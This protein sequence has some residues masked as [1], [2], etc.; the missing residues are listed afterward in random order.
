MEVSVDPAEMAHEQPGKTMRIFISYN[1]QNSAFVS[2]IV[3][4]LKDGIV[5]SREIFFDQ[6]NLRGGQQWTDEIQQALLGSDACIV[7]IGEQGIGNWQG[8]E[9]LAAINQYVDTRGEFRVIPVIIPHSNREQMQK[10]FPWFLADMQW[11]EFATETDPDAFQKLVDGLLKGEASAFRPGRDTNPYKG[12]DF[13]DVQDAPLFFGRT[14]DLN[15]VFYKKLLLHT[16]TGSRFLAIVGDSGSGKSSFARAGLLAA[17]QA[18]RFSGSEHWKQVI[19]NPEDNPL[20]KLS[21]ALQAAGMIPDAKKLEDEAKADVAAL[22]RAVEIYGRKMILLVDQFEEV[23]TQCKEHAIRE[24]FLN[25]ILEALKSQHFICIITLRSDFYASFSS[26]TAFADALQANNYTITGFDYTAAGAEWER[27][28]KAIIQKPARMMGVRISPSLT[29]KIIQDCKGISGVLPV[30]QLALSRLYN[31]KREDVASI[32]SQHYDTL[33]NNKGIAGIIEA[34]ANNCWNGLTRDGSDKRMDGLIK[35]IFI[36]LVE[37]TQN[38]EDVRKTVSKAELIRNLGV[39]FSQHEVEDMLAVLSGAE[40]RLIRI[41]KDDSDSGIF[42]VDVIHEVLIRQWELFRKWINERREAIRYRDMLEEHLADIAVLTGRRLAEAEKWIDNNKDLATPEIHLLVARSRKN[43]NRI[44]Y[45]IGAVL[46]IGV[47]SALSAWLYQP[48]RQCNNCALVKTWREGNYDVDEVHTLVLSGIDNIKY[49]RCFG[50][51][52]SLTLAGSDGEYLSQ[53]SIDSLPQRLKYLS[54]E[55]FMVNDTV[56]QFATF[57]QLQTLSI[58]HLSGLRRLSITGLDSLTGLHLVG[59][60]SYKTLAGIGEL[61]NLHTLTLSNLRNVRSLAG[62]EGFANLQ[63]LTLSTLSI[64]SLD[65]IQGLK[66]LQTLA[67]Y[68]LPDVHDLL[69]IEKLKKSLQVLSIESHIDTLAGIENMTNLH[70]LGLTG[71]RIQSLAAL[72]NLR[73]LQT[74]YLSDIDKPILPSIQKLKSLHHLTLSKVHEDS[75]A[76]IQ[77]LDSLETLTLSDIQI[78]DLRALGSLNLHALYLSDLRS[79]NGLAGI[80]NLKNLQTLKI[81]FLG[82]IGPF[83]LTGLETLQHLTTFSAESFTGFNGIHDL[84]VIKQL[85]SLQS[86]R[87]SSLELHNLEGIEELTNLRTLD[88]SL[89]RDIDLEGIAGCKSLQNL[90]LSSLSYLGLEGIEQLKNLRV[91]QMSGISQLADDIPIT[92][93][94]LKEMTRIDTLVII[95]SKLANLDF[96]DDDLHVST[97]VYD[98]LRF[99]NG[100]ERNLSKAKRMRQT[101]FL[102]WPYYRGG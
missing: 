94:V 65:S 61:K 34:H 96:I 56:L 67:M 68:G 4:R 19:I 81:D 15:W 47:L 25:N 11:I 45:V 76:V 33:T 43:V 73:R 95:G 39:Q 91:L 31:L 98:D 10:N 49:L 44:K 71:L 5:I 55:G 38:K 74:L 3:Q 13:F 42:W 83:D 8:K 36:Q 48:Y 63:N 14:F 84:S 37:L 22:R 51:L 70:T 20:L 26:F 79:L 78:K 2:S 23:I 29:A 52:D 54:I 28:L 24:V 99:T 88:L 17:L 1:R 72:E 18:G 66:S 16:K 86:L 100:G 87:L 21:S 35:A 9:V 82:G 6:D 69:A 30:L 46:V 90:V 80:E 77:Q 41:K 85:K 102:Y 97:I 53:A 27:Y 57:P 64:S 60:N 32:Q 92:I 58:A 75:L 62:I 101:K 7:F 40:I 93:P 59:L 89:M 12:L 50:R